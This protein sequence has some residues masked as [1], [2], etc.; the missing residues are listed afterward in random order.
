LR[1]NLLDLVVFVDV[2][3]REGSVILVDFGGGEDIV[4][5]VVH[6]D[7][8]LATGRNGGRHLYGVRVS[9]VGL[10]DPVR[11]FVVGFPLKVVR[12][13]AERVG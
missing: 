11:V 1:V 7:V 4:V 8:W 6:V 12:C 3:G 5:L 9:A 2:F 10:L 13:F